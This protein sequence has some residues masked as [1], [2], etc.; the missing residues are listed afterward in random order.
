MDAAIGAAGL[1]R[2]RSLEAR[3]L[4]PY[5][6]AMALA[7]AGM[8]AQSA[9]LLPVPLVQGWVLD[10]LLAGLGPGGYGARAGLARAI[11]AGLGA[12]AALHLG[13][14]ALGWRA[15]ATM[16]RVSLEVVRGL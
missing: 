12:I 9:L 4:S 8:L 13:R 6:G 11:V 14:M 5:R 7:L 15:L 2:L 10:R 3:F 1:G 16:N